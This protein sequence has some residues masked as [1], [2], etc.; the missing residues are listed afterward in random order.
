MKAKSKDRKFL[1]SLNNQTTTTIPKIEASQY[2]NA[3][4][5]YFMKFLK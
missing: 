4:L 2:G 5:K 1:V 3:F